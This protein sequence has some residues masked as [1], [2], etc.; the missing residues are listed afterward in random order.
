MAP[1]STT[2]PQEPTS[3]PAARPKGRFAERLAALRQEA[4]E[5][6]QSDAPP[7][8]AAPEEG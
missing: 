6:R 3:T 5:A 8:Q 2:Q 4:R 7:A 1:D